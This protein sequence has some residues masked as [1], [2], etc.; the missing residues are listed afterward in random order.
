L[1][2]SRSFVFSKKALLAQGETDLRK[3]VE[4]SKHRRGD[5]VIA[6]ALDLLERVRIREAP[7]H[8][9]R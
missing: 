5:S 3:S 4:A 6:T 2:E 1:H 8:R 7:K 9:Q